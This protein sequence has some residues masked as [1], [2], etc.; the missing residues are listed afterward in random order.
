MT[1]KAEKTVRVKATGG[2]DVIDPN[3]EIGSKLKALYSS[4]Q[5]EPIPDRFLDLLDKLDE[6]ERRSADQSKA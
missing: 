4:L 3:S 2:W 6:S 5:D 1:E